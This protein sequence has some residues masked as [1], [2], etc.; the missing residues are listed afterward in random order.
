[1]T[2]GPADLS[3]HT[4]TVAGVS[5]SFMLSLAVIGIIFGTTHRTYRGYWW[6]LGS[7]W[8]AP[9]G[10]GLL[11]LREAWPLAA[12]PGVLLMLAWPMFIVQ[13]LRHF[14]VRDAQFTSTAV[15]GMVYLACF[16]LCIVPWGSQMAPEVQA[17]A[18]AVGVLV[19]HL[20]TATVILR[21]NTPARSQT[22]TMLV[23]VVALLGAMPV[24]RLLWVQ[25]VTGA[26]LAGSPLLG[27]GVV[28]PL[29]IGM[30]CIA[31]LC[32][33]LTQERTVNDLH[34]T[35]RQLRVLADID[36]LTQV[37]NRRRIEELAERIVGKMGSKPTVLMLFDIDHFKRINDTHGHATGDD[38]LRAVARCARETLRTRDVLGRIGGDEFMLLLPGASVDHAL[39]IADRITRRL[40]AQRKT[41]RLPLSLS[42]GVV[43]IEVGETI[44]SARRRADQA[45]YEAKRQGRRRAVPAER[46]GHDTVFGQSRPL[47]LD[48]LQQL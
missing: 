4:P 34:E 43:Q 37:P 3:I 36:M 25:L 24:A 5:V 16:V 32:L 1:M 28:L 18:Y 38:A 7:M 48:A 39:Q 45:L 46:H 21:F 44:E 30:L 10:A 33:V 2:P 42:F 35:Q 23:V 9:L 47:G 17:A 13:G 6:W 41:T 26:S 15:D 29:A 31:F 27:Y 40:D 14:Y 19:L 11:T 8:L 12:L 22:L 20:Y